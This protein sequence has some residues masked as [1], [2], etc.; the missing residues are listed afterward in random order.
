ML[1][2]LL[3]SN[4]Y[5]GRRVAC[6][7]DVLPTTPH[8]ALDTSAVIRSWKEKLPKSHFLT[9]SSIYTYREKDA[10]LS[11]SGFMPNERDIN[12]AFCRILE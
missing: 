2:D 8:S 9:F 7:I 3:H 1:N 12:T 10:R 5:E 4:D 11:F 6:R